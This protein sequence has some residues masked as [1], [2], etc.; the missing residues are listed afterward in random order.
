[1]WETLWGKL[2]RKKSRREEKKGTLRVEKKEQT[3]GKSKKVRSKK[4]GMK[5]AGRQKKRG[6]GNKPGQIQRADH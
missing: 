6:N 5:R 3:G 2:S 4:K 1:V